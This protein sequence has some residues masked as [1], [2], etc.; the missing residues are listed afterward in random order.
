MNCKSFTLVNQQAVNQSSK[1]SVYKNNLKH[2]AGKNLLVRISKI[3]LAAQERKQHFQT[4][5]K[6]RPV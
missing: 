2:Y 4:I 5:C 6:T 3:K 1:S